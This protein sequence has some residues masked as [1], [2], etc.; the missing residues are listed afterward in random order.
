MKFEYHLVVSRDGIENPSELLPSFVKNALN[1][2]ELSLS[3]DFKLPSSDRLPG[4]DAAVLAAMA[5][6]R[7]YKMGYNISSF[8]SSLL[9]C[10]VLLE[11]ALSRSKHNYDMLLALVKIYMFLGAGSLAVERYAQLSIKNLQNVT[12]SWILFTRISTIHPHPV[13]DSQH[14]QS[15]GAFDPLWAMYDI[16]LWQTRAA[17]L[18]MQ[19]LHKLQ[20]NNSWT[21]AL[22]ALGTKRVLYNGFM[23]LVLV[24]ECSRIQRLRSPAGDHEFQMALI[25]V[26][27]KLQFTRDTKAF[28]NY[29]SANQMTFEMALP[30]AD[31]H[32]LPNDK[33]IAANL[34]QAEIWDRLSDSKSTCI[35]PGQLFRLRD[36]SQDD[37]N[38]AADV[39]EYT[40]EFSQQIYTTF[41]IMA[42][43]AESGAW[44][45][46]TI[47]FVTQGLDKVN[48]LVELLVKCEA[49]YDVI[50]QFK[51]GRV[52]QLSWEMLTTCYLKL[53]ICQM[54][55]R[56]NAWVSEL[57]RRPGTPFPPV[58]K[59]MLETILKGCQSLAT[60]IWT[61]AT[62]IRADVEKPEF[63]DDLCR[64][65]KGQDEISKNLDRLATDDVN[66]RS[67]CQ[68]LQE[69]WLDAWEGVIKTKIS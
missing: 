39:E 31:I 5:L 17:E 69:S 11:M 67:I 60:Q 16:L 43:A 30:S 61:D 58:V 51:E 54:I 64:R 56:G 41:A 19:S 68:K 22:D 13:N 25:S 10:I 66:V 57:Q 33:W 4:D 46:N 18:N 23:R 55:K 8:G 28:P 6:I 3:L 34:R 20:Q 52:K 42:R 27:K 7:M 47:L 24:A 63:L 15:N 48:I 53:E 32:S 65:V 38:T 44:K 62:N 37:A 50:R 29:E 9:R 40:Y 35:N 45:P 26:P 12:L 1:L 59:K 2:Y 14:G 21:M 36:G 49:H